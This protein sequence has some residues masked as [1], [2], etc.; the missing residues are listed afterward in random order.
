MENKT[1]DVSWDA[2]TVNMKA[3]GVYEALCI[4]RTLPDKAY[5]G[6]GMEVRCTE[7]DVLT[8]TK[9]VQKYTSRKGQ[10]GDLYTI[11]A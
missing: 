8:I 7:P 4:P 6:G 10:T 5:Y 1:I 9:V 3:G 11:K 2:S